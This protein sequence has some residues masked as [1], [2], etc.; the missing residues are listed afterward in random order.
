MET[1]LPTTE[2]CNAPERERAADITASFA[3]ILLALGRGE[4]IR[5]LEAIAA[6]LIN[7][8]EVAAGN[9]QTGSPAD[10]PGAAHQQRF[11]CQLQ[12]LMAAL[13]LA[14]Q[15]G[16]VEDHPAYASCLRIARRAMAGAIHDPTGGATRFHLIDAA[17]DWARGMLPCATLGGFVFYRQDGSLL[18]VN[19]LA[20]REVENSDT[21]A[22]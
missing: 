22:V 14:P 5:T 16:A 18:G 7:Q 9:D 3:Q 17:P 2:P 15:R 19:L 6:T 11:A 12:A 21:D 13:A 4:Q 10:D 20:D 8:A 1:D